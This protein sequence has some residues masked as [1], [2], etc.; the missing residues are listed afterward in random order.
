MRFMVLV[1]P[2][3]DWSAAP[4]T[5]P[6]AGLA[7]AMAGYTKKLKR[8]GALLALDVIGGYWIIE[9]KSKEEA[10]EWAKRVP[11]SHDHSI[12]VRQVQE[13]AG[14]APEESKP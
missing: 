8:A 10:V 1:I 4:G 13:P 9:V 5:L 3:G 6:Q 2:K 12:E 7:G 14:A 11:A